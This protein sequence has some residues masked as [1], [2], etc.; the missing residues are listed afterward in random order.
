MTSS[1]LREQGRGFRQC[2]VLARQL[3]FQLLD[4]LAILLAL[5]TPGLDL[6]GTVGIGAGKPCAKRLS[7]RHTAPS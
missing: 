2:L 5:V 3:L 1:L 7:A 6:G 4:L